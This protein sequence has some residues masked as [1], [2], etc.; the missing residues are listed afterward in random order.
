M[1]MLMLISLM[2]MPLEGMDRLLDKMSRSPRKDEK[3]EKEERPSSPRGERHKKDDKEKPKTPRDDKQKNVAD[4]LKGDKQKPLSRDITLTRFAD[5]RA[6][7]PANSRDSKSASPLKGNSASPSRPKANTIGKR[8]SLDWTAALEETKKQTHMD[9]SLKKWSEKDAAEENLK[10]LFEEFSNADQKRQ[11]EIYCIVMRTS[12][13][14]AT[15][16]AMASNFFEVSHKIATLALYNI[17]NFWSTNT[18][19]ARNEINTLYKA[20]FD[21]KEAYVNQ[22]SAQ[23]PR[24]NKWACEKVALTNQN[25]PIFKLLAQIE[26]LKTKYPQYS[27]DLEPEIF[28]LTEPKLS[29]PKK[30]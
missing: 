22:L 12:V 2:I 4:D 28:L 20:L 1:K 18:E 25:S 13:V 26:A 9:D 10:K 24:R 14:S 8:Y 27:K 11:Q 21:A 3:K 17:P 15:K 7:E 23:A 16:E 5:R 19:E 30:P 29:E 6:S